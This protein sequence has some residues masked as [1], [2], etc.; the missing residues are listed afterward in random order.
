MMEE[1]KAQKE[2]LEKKLNRLEDTHVK[3]FSSYIS[4]E[5]AYRDS[6]KHIREVYK[7]LSKVCD[8]LGT[9]IPVRL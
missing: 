6:A 3:K 9:P 7:E 5:T 1:L 2:A 4:T 8:E